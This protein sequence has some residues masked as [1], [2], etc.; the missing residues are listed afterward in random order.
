MKKFRGF[1]RIFHVQA[2]SY[3]KTVTL[4][5]ESQDIDELRLLDVDHP[6]S[7]CIQALQD[8]NELNGTMQ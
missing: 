3:A 7:L 1:Y 5:L 8:H 6:P 2:R 4:L